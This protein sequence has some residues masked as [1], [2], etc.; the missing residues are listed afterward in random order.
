MT[1]HPM[2]FLPWA[3]KARILKQITPSDWAEYNTE[4][5]T[6]QC[7]VWEWEIQ[8]PSFPFCFA[9]TFLCGVSRSVSSRLPLLLNG[10]AGAV[11]LLG[12]LGARLC[13]DCDKMQKKMFGLSQLCSPPVGACQS[14]SSQPCGLLSPPQSWKPVWSSAI[15]M[16]ISHL[17]HLPCAKPHE[18]N[19]VVLIWEMY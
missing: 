14:A 6:G 8:E 17:D 16:P 2:A 13:K 9:L 1:L 7:P 5:R 10:E 11:H 12:S 19:D 4:K 3:E 15:F 18:N